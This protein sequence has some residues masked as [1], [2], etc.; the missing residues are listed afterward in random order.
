[1]SDYRIPVLKPVNK[2][3]R[4]F[5]IAAFDVE[6][7]AERFV[8][9][10]VVLPTGE[11]HVFR[12]P[13]QLV[14]FIQC[15]PECLWFAHNAIYDV[16]VLLPHMGQWDVTLYK[17]RFVEARYRN[18]KQVTRIRDSLWFWPMSLHKVG[19]VIGLQKLDIGLSEDKEKVDWDAKIAEVGWEQL[20]EY[21]LR[22]AEIVQKAMTLFQQSLNELGGEL[23]P[24]LAST[25]FDLFRRAFLSDTYQVPDLIQNKFARQAYFGGR[26]ENLVVGIVQNVK[27]YDVN[28]MYP[29]VMKTYAFPDPNTLIG[30][31]E[32]G[33]VDNILRYEG[34]SECVVEVPPS[35]LPPLPIRANGKTVFPYGRLE[36]TW[37]HL[38]LRFAM[39]LGARV[40]N[41]RRQMIATKTC[42]PF[43][44][45]VDTLYSLRMQHKQN[46]DPREHVV[47]LMLNSLYGKFGEDPDGDGL[48]VLTPGERFTDPSQIPV[49]AEQ[50]EIDEADFILVPKNRQYHA[51]NYI[52]IWAAY[53]TAAARVELLKRA[54]Q[55]S[56]VYYM[57]TDSLMTPD[58][59][60][61]GSGLGEL[62]LELEADEVRIEAPKLYV[63]YRNGQV[64]KQAARG[65]PAP[66]VMDFIQNGK[67]S[68]VKPLKILEAIRRNLRPSLWIVA[69]KA[70]DE[71]FPKRL[72]VPGS[73]TLRELLPWPA[74]WLERVAETPRSRLQDL[75][76]ALARSAGGLL[77]ALRFGLSHRV[78]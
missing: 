53:V 47:K 44:G 11:K 73:G 57:D 36:G 69:T 22:D 58:T 70:R 63:A 12:N 54:L 55:C 21:C 25:A 26:T 50:W 5:P 23:H 33:T 71:S 4:T 41:I 37:T 39:E 15:H 2:K 14:T 72:P 45:Y 78:P 32:G 46:K 35:R 76:S 17:G 30:P 24:T 61:T 29:F 27:F 20:A 9:G 75:V 48:R 65:I 28:S 1:L 60:P 31:M 19:Q 13:K 10:A 64:V 3:P 56:T 18:G 34:V 42:N 59:L 68:Y 52:T 6:G 66:L 43:R 74:Q 67:V 49:G 77:N 40:V 8:L 62:K 7:D 16:G 51:S 38:E